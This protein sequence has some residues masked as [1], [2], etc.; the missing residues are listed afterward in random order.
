MRKSKLV[1]YL[2]PGTMAGKLPSMK[3]LYF[4]LLGLLAN[5]TTHA[6]VVLTPDGGGAFS[7]TASNA[8]FFQWAIDN[9]GSTSGSFGVVGTGYG[10]QSSVLSANST[11]SLEVNF[12]SAPGREFDIASFQ[13]ST[14]IWA[15]GGA[16]FSVPRVSVYVVTDG[17]A[18][19]LFQ[20]ESPE[21]LPA[22][23]AQ[24]YAYSGG[25]P[26]ADYF[27]I[28]TSTIDIS[29]FVVGRSDFALRFVSTTGWPGELGY[30]GAFYQ[31][32]SAP[33]TLTGEML[34]IPEPAGISLLVVSVLA[35]AVRFFQRRTRVCPNR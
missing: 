20:W 33:F 13:L 19:R 17:M 24:R 10:V 35:G 14:A 11:A 8:N 3:T 26:A 21:L 22:G 15:Y 9:G 5:L 23:T 12:Q 25:S 4:L 27:G 2:L 34:P 6:A 30:G 1:D 29:E 28:Y 16:S 7:V 31:A 32:N 18:T